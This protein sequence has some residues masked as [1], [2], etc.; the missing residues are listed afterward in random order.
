MKTIKKK[1]N[2]KGFMSIEAIMSMSVVLM[3]IV[4]GVSI[5]SYMIPRQAIEEDVHLLGRVAKME[6]TLSDVQ[7][8]EFQD[9][10]VSRG[11]AKTRT[12]VTVELYKESTSGLC[13]SLLSPATKV[14]RGDKYTTAPCAGSYSVLKVVAKVPAKKNAVSATLGFFGVDS[15]PLSNDYVF[16][17]RVMS[18]YYPGG[19]A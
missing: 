17:E 1:L 3:V 2:Q 16:E 6:G 11:L 8:I 19:G 12:D 10:M 4:L 13:S 7:K 9:K 15:S 14:Q 5:F 18:E